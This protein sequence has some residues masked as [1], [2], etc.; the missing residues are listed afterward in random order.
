MSKKL[1][2]TL[3][4]FTWHVYIIFKSSLKIKNTKLKVFLFNLKLCLRN[5]TKGKCFTFMLLQMKT[6]KL[7]SR[8]IEE[9]RMD[10]L[11]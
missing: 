4:R 1:Y 3:K 10:P 11:A 7:F 9:P 2:V 8:K 6:H 5:S